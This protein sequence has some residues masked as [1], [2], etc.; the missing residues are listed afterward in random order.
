ML[1]ATDTDAD[2]DTP[3]ADLMAKYKKT[4]LQPAQSDVEKW[5]IFEQASSVEENDF[6]AL[7]GPLVFQLV[8]GPHFGLPTDEA[9]VEDLKKKLHKK[10]EGYERILTQHTYVAGPNLTIVDLFHLPNGTILAGTGAVPALTDGT[11][12]HVMEWW[13]KLSNLPAWKKINAEVQEAVSAMRAAKE[14][15]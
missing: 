9:R 1:L 2:A 6:D 15:K 5:G 4:D 3:F 12:P 11:L 7:A 10:L 14:K 8:F 13:A